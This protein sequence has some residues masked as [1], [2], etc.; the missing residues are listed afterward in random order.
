MQR[1][2]DAAVLVQRRIMAIL[3]TFGGKTLVDGHTE[4]TSAIRTTRTIVGIRGTCK[5]RLAPP[6]SFHAHTCIGWVPPPGCQQCLPM[7]PS[8]R[9]AAPESNHA[10]PRRPCPTRLAAAADVEPVFLETVHRVIVASSISSSSSSTSS[11][12]VGIAPV[13]HVVFLGGS[14]GAAAHREERL[15]RTGYRRGS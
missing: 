3:T 11:K 8:L 2:T 14:S 6:A 10:T 13:G 9:I 4:R 12:P 1:Q 7:L 5:A 15:W